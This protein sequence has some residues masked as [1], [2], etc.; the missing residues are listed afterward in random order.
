VKT[1]AY[2][3]PVS[4]PFQQEFVEGISR[5]LPTDVEIRAICLNGLPEARKHWNTEP[6][7]ITLEGP[8]RHCLIQTLEQLSPSLI[9]AAPYSYRL[10]HSAVRF[11]RKKKIPYII[12]PNEIMTHNSRGLRVVARKALFRLV[13]KN[14]VAIAAMG[15]AACRFYSELF[16]GP[17]ENIPYCFDLSPLLSFTPHNNADEI[18]FLY[19]GQL[20]EVRRPL[21]TIRV[22]AELVRQHSDRSLR[23]I[24]SGRGAQYDDCLKAIDEL[25]ITERV[26]WMNDFA[27]WRDIH[28]VYQNA[29]ILLALQDHGGWGLVVPEAMAAGMTVVSTRMVQSADSLII[30]GY[31]GLLVSQDPRDIAE[32][33][34]ELIDSPES[35]AAFRERARKAV[36]SVDVSRIAK[37][38][39]RFFTKFL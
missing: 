29:D 2:I 34:G 20:I 39:A 38:A 15:D 32:K 4:S 11:A 25:G 30:D 31:N 19:S 6:F 18:T 24:I 26:T 28:T 35:L 12:G 17:I 13:T 5:E 27:D 23:L 16:K 37:R 9:V 36:M 7:G 33:I 8:K 21:L 3:T 1:I 14:A 22:F 10:V